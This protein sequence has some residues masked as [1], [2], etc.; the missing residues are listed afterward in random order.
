[1]AIENFL[2]VE[3]AADVIGCTPGY[4]RR[5]CREG[6]ICGKKVSARCWLVPVEEAS[7]MR[8]QP[9]KTGRPKISAKSA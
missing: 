5:M 8:N 3:E 7:K 9:Y 4:V 2:T 1:M 6:A